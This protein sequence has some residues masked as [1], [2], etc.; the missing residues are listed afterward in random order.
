[1]VHE[2]MSQFENSL[3]ILAGDY[4]LILNPEMDCFNFVHLNNP[5]AR[6]KVCN[7]M[8]E[9]NCLDC[10]REN[11]LENREYTWFKR[12]PV[13]KA[14]LDFFFISDNLYTDLECSLI[15]SGYRTDHSLIYISLDYISLD[16][17]KFKK[18]ISYWKFN[19]SILTEVTY[20]NK[21]KQVIKE[22][23]ILFGFI[24]L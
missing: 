11:H 13:K 14:R 10:W 19:N 2:K 18:G 15:L 16:L 4:N 21:V 1:M 17:D 24:N 5:N 7:I 22:Q 23:N 3:F 6:D 12:N 8:S 9:Y 20:V